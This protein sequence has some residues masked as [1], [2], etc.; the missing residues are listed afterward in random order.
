M[1]TVPAFAEP[2]ADPGEGPVLVHRQVALECG[3]MRIQGRLTL[4]M[5]A[6][7]RRVLDFLNRSEPF[8]SLIDGD[9]QHL[10]RRTAITRVFE[11]RA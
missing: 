8:L 4:D 10:V 11:S 1:L 6:E 5:P 3:A 7:R 9:R 2:E